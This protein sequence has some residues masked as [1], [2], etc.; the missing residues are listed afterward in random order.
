MPAKY[1][2][3]SIYKLSVRNVRYIVSNTLKEGGGVI[4]FATAMLPDLGRG[5]AYREFPDVHIYGHC[6]V[7]LSDL[8]VLG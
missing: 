3:T 7:R 1:S 8:Y 2:Y 5:R 4:E 6:I